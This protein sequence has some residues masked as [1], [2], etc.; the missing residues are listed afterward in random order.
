MDH[1][2]VGDPDGPGRP[3]S[4]TVP[5]KLAD[6]GSVTSWFGP[7]LT[8]GARFATIVTSSLLLTEPSVAVSRKT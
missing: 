1:A 2:I 3:S 8:A 5:S 6:D 7:A 4:E